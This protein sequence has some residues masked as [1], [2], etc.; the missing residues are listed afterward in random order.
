M[1]L[2]VSDLFYDCFM[3]IVA[4]FVHV[5][6]VVYHTNDLRKQLPHL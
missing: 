3:N 2:R 1:R 4:K 5:I 6:L